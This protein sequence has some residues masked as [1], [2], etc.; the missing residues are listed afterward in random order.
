MPM[1]KD[2][3]WALEELIDKRSVAEVLS[4][5]ADICSEKAMH[6][7]ENWQDHALARAW[8]KVSG[9]VDRCTRT[10]RKVNLS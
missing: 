2:D 7:D 8:R 1:N 6:I 5:I 4:T 10:V 9:I 3:F